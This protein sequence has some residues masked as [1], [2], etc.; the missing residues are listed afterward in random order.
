MVHRV[1][2][3]T[4]GEKGIEK[5]KG[6]F[7]CESKKDINPLLELEKE[8]HEEIRPGYICAIYNTKFK[9]LEIGL[10]KVTYDYELTQTKQSEIY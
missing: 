5:M 7:T 8:I 6:E 4:I 2:L 10:I 1:A 3:M 9:Y